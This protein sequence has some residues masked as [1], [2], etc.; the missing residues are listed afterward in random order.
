MSLLSAHGYSSCLGLGDCDKPGQILLHCVV[1]PGRWTTEMESHRMLTGARERSSVVYELY[2]FSLVR[3]GHQSDSL[4]A[5]LL[6]RKNVNLG[7]HR[8]KLYFDPKATMDFMNL[9]RKSYPWQQNSL[10]FPSCLAHPC[11][12]HHWLKYTPVRIFDF[13]KYHFPY[14]N[15]Y[16][17]PNIMI[18]QWTEN[19][20][21]LRE[22]TNGSQRCLPHWF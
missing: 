19:K 10:T 3:K 17:L 18:W 8:E 12:H 14:S 5:K 21:V 16:Y 11:P 15:L 13:S 20:W 1:I 4:H 7:W 22:G 9:N 6:S 2:S